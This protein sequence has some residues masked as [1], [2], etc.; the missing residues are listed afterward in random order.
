MPLEEEAE[1]IDEDLDGMPM[2]DEELDGVPMPEEGDEEDIDGVPMEAD[3]P[4][5]S[6]AQDSRFT[7]GSWSMVCFFG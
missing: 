6:P 2:P 3:E 1:L 4:A 7:T 5:A